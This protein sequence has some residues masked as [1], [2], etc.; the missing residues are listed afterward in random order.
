MVGVRN[1]NFSLS[2][3]RFSWE[4]SR[5]FFGSG[6]DSGPLFTSMELGFLRFLLFPAVETVPGL[7]EPLSQLTLSTNVIVAVLILLRPTL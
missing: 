6:L 2:N 1:E 3:P 4:S 5:E 7:Y